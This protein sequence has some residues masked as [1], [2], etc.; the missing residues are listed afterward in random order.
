MWRSKE[1]EREKEREVVLEC[2]PRHN[3]YMVLGK[4]KGWRGHSQG[5]GRTWGLDRGTKEKGTPKGKGQRLGKNTP[6]KVMK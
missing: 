3:D 1:R 6:K 5:Y 2:V 4:Q